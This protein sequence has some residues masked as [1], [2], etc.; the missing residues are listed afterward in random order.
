MSE[1]KP[2]P[3]C[4]SDNVTVKGAE[5]TGPNPYVYCRKCHTHGPQRISYLGAKNAWNRRAESQCESV[6]VN[7]EN[8]DGDADS[9]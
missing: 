2:C 8:G 1:L 4:G 5:I 9:D 6:Q 3:F 7:V